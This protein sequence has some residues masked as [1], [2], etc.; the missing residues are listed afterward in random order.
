MNDDFDISRIQRA[1]RPRRPRDS[2]DRKIRER[3]LRAF[4]EEADEKRS[5]TDSSEVDLVVLDLDLERDEPFAEGSRGGRSWL[6]RV[7]VAAAVALLVGFVAMLSLDDEPEVTPA[8]QNETAIGEFCST[9]FE[10]L[11]GV[12]VE[13]DRS[14]SS[15]FES[16]ALRNLELLSQRYADL[17]DEVADP[18][19]SEVRAMGDE[20]LLRAAQVRLDVTV[21]R[22]DGQTPESM[23][24]LIADL[25]DAIE[26]LPG[27]TSCRVSDL[28]GG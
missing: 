9:K 25:A 26:Q 20:F 14:P 13:F 12:F 7:A 2:A 11:V 16:R 19:A 22:R 6:Y 5:S 18:L 4:D 21:E 27:S 10:E 3:M 24:L 1:D 28:R 17:A 23:T 8:A 15:E